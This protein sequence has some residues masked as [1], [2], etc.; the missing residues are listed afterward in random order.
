MIEERKIF[1]LLGRCLMRRLDGMLV[2]AD[3][4]YGYSIQDEVPQLLRDEAIVLEN[5]IS[6]QI[7]NKMTGDFNHSE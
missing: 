6:G 4:S 5:K 1:D 7:R 3:F 2:N